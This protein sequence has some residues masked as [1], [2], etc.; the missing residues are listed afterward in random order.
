MVRINELCG[1]LM[2]TSS[3]VSSFK[4]RPA[5]S[6]EFLRGLMIN[7]V[8]FMVIAAG[9]CLANAQERE[10][11]DPLANYTGSG[12]V[13]CPCFVAGEQAGAVFDAPSE[14]YPIEILRIGIGWGSYFGGTPQ[15]VEQAVNL[16][17]AGL[18]NPG[19]PLFVLLGPVLADGY[20]NE[21]DIEPIPGE[22]TLDSGPFAVTLEF[23]NANAGDPYAPSMIHDGN[24]CQ[25]GKNVIYA[26]PGGW[27]DACLLGVTGDWV[28]YVVYRQVNCNGTGI[29]DEYVVT[30]GSPAFLMPPS[31]NPFGSNT[32]IEFVLGDGGRTAIT[33]Y[34]VTGR[35][36]ANVTDSVLPAGLHSV[37]WDGAASDGEKLPSGV[38]FVELRAGSH[39]TVRKVLLAK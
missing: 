10:E 1:K 3:V 29:G 15:Q 33:V 35:R 26:V 9:A 16:Y 39:R 28:V 2:L 11:E 21:F 25:S 23:A 32:R 22:I 7:A 5:V 30:S 31:P 8:A 38:Y 36:V 17:E 19:V 34:D 20:I 6:I 27:S 18:P 12:Q 14:H 24:G 4:A 37:S 13:V